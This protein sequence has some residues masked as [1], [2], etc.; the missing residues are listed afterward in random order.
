MTTQNTTTAPTF[1]DWLNGV[2]SRR[3]S[4][5]TRIGWGRLAAFVAIVATWAFGSYYGLIALPNIAALGGLL[6]IVAALAVLVGP[7]AAVLN[8]RTWVRVIGVV[9]AF[10]GGAI[11]ATQ[12][13]NLAGVFTGYSLWNTLGFVVV[14]SATIVV[15]WWLCRV[16]RQAPRPR[17]TTPSNPTV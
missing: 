12:G 16:P 1:A 13:A 2:F 5:N 3:Q 4:R 14:T 11:L 6:G 15:G 10:V 7:F 9:V 8:R 17:P